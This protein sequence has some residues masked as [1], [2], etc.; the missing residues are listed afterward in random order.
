MYAVIA[1]LTWPKYMEE[2]IDSQNLE[3]LTWLKEILTFLN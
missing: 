1:I 2:R 3:M